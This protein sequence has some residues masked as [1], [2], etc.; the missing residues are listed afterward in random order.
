L[1]ELREL[2]RGVHPQV[3]ADRGL[4][5]AIQEA[6]DRSTVPVGVDVAIPGRLPETVEATAY[7]AVCEALA[8]IAK[9]SQ[10]TRAQVR[11]RVVADQLV[12]EIR[13]D[14][15][16]GANPGAG[17]GLVGLADRIAVA[18][19]RLFLSSPRGGPTVVQVEI[20]CGDGS[21]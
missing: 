21:K 14:G 5:A 10:A 6:A 16:G 1:A 11:G 2:I 18:D 4:P 20:P 19:G 9:H 13:D 17:T 12:L 7:Y 3:L 8:N 15:V